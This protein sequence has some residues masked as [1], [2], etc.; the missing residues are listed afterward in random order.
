MSRMSGASKKGNNATIQPRT[1]ILLKWC[2]RHI[3]NAF[4]IVSYSEW[5]CCYV[6]LY[7]NALP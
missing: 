1:T 3:F 6:C 4:T 5:C 2:S 7:S